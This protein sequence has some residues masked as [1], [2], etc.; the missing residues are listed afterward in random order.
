MSDH[1]NE[2]APH[3]L[4]PYYAVFIALVALTGFTIWVA[5]FVEDHHV[6]HKW[7]FIIAMAIASCKATMVGLYFMHLKFETRSLLIVVAVP[8]VLTLVLVGMLSP[9]IGGLGR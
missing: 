7:A 1:A 9:D 3:S 4:L 2:H 8:L 5:D 6:S